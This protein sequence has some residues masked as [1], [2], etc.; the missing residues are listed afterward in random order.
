MVIESHFGCHKVYIDQNGSN[1]NC[2]YPYPEKPSM[3]FDLGWPYFDMTLGYIFVQINKSPH[4]EC[5]N[6]MT[7]LGGL[8]LKYWKVNYY[9]MQKHSCFN[10]F[11]I[12][13]LLK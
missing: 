12:I 5:P 9:L 13:P 7:T 1:F 4:D 10:E 8:N 11:F 6:I 2:F 3:G